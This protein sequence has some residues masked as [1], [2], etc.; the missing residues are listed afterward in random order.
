MHAAGLNHEGHSTEE[1][2]FFLRA[3]RF[4]SPKWQEVL[5]TLDGRRHFSQQLLQVFIALHEVD[6]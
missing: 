2:L 1:M 6:L 5:S 4:F 3:G